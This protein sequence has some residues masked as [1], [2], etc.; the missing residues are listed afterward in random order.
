MAAD[1]GT[2]A[3]HPLRAA[4]G[5]ALEI[6]L[7]RAIAL[8]PETRAALVGLE[9]RELAL[10]LQAP[11]LALRLKVVDGRVTVGPDHA[12]TEADLS[13]QSTLGAMLAQLLPGRDAGA[14]PVGKV[15]ISGDAEL[16]RRVQQLMQRYDPDIE[17]AFT[18]VFGDVIGVQ[19]ARAL[20][21]AFDWSRDTA[22]TLARDTAE[23]LSEESRDLVPKAE[24]DAFLDEVDEVRDRAE[25][26]ERKVARVRGRVTDGGGKG[27]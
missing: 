25:R 14:L 15:R 11:P 27:I 10:A 8:D 16:A 22:S 9:G 18:R 23:Y 4:L 13:V 21:R 1:T 5:R 24:L 12:A 3:R 7:D 26:L 17:E 19:V 20:K 6:A 2:P